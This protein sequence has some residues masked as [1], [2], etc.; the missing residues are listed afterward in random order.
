M[1]LE[2]T[3]IQATGLSHMNM[4]G[5]AP[6]AACQ[7]LSG[8]GHDASHD[9]RATCQ[10]Q[11]IK[12]TL[13]PVW[14]EQHI[15]EP[16]YFGEALEFTVYDQGM[17]TAKTEGKAVLPPEYFWPNGFEG[18]L[19]LQDL[20]H[21]NLFVAIRPIV[22]YVETQMDP[23]GQVLQPGMEM[24]QPGMEAMQMEELQP[25]MQ[26]VQPGVQDA[27]MQQD[28]QDYQPYLEG[29]P[30][31][32]QVTVIQAIGLQHMMHF[33]G[34]SPYVVV[35]VDHVNTHEKLKKTKFQTKVL[36]GL[37]PVWNESQ[38]LDPW[39][40]GEPIKF[41]VYDKGLVGSKTEGV[42][43]LPSEAFYPNGFQGPLTLAN[44]EHSQ[45]YVNIVPV[46]PSV[47]DLQLEVTIIQANN[48]K[49]LMH[50]TGDAPYV[51][52]Q[53]DHKK[54]RSKTTKHQTKVA[55][56]SPNP[57]DPV[58]NETFMLGPWSWDEALEFV[59]YDKGLLNAKSEGKATIGAEHFYPLGF[60]GI[61]PLDSNP[62]ATVMVR[63]VPAGPWSP[64]ATGQ[65]RPGPVGV[66]VVGR[67]S[68]P[69]QTGYP[70][71][72]VAQ[73]PAQPPATSM[74]MMAMPPTTNWPSP[75]AQPAVGSRSLLQ[76]GSAMPVPHA[77]TQFL[78]QAQFQPQAQPAFGGSL[79][80]PPAS[81]VPP[82]TSTQ[83]Q[84]SFVAPP[85]AGA[86]YRAASPL[87][88]GPPVEGQPAPPQI[89]PSQSMR[90]YTNVGAMPATLSPSGVSAFRAPAISP[91]T[92]AS[93]MRL[94]GTSSQGGLQ[95]PPW[96]SRPVPPRSTFATADRNNDGVVTKAEFMAALQGLSGRR[97]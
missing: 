14:N 84:A 32:L 15:L 19:P 85:P 77:Q 51:V 18:Q 7:V 73:L 87:R 31:R 66:P 29:P 12:G 94:P 82:T 21:A 4:L 42:V 28:A 46:G 74:T 25:G 52:A 5:D 93:S 70:A 40:V 36:K 59:V 80:A 1:K 86:Q 50:F 58:F 64:N 72:Q 44:K 79:M 88:F 24:M 39:H 71:Q 53:V 49:H 92:M 6:Y 9:H 35:E 97:L 37:D 34:D 23:N 20:E 48:L 11:P 22:D 57:L 83:F 91:G 63:I 69:A 68:L 8:N 43:T 62:E 96:G 27:P 38:E 76:P 16:W 10:T 67:T 95:A 33:T 81:R 65:G 47:K 60:E 75:P 13:E 3:F 90:S 89:P 54:S 55:K 2:V 45:L 61:V 56:N 41:S 78:P 30:L 26:A 17:L